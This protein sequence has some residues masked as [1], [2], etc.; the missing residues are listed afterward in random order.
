M[1]EKGILY[2]GT[3]ETGPMGDSGCIGGHI[4]SSVSKDNIPNEHE[5]SNFG[6]IGNPYTYDDGNGTIMV[7]WMTK[8]IIFSI[9]KISGFMFINDYVR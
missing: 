1:L 6:C 3:D 4:E 9:T 8:N 7:V 2:Y 5:Q